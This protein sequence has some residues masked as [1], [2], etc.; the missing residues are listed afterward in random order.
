MILNQN[1]LNCFSVSTISTAF[2]SMN[3]L[4]YNDGEISRTQRGQWLQ[5][6]RPKSDDLFWVKRERKSLGLLGPL[7]S[8]KYLEMISPI[9]TLKL[10]VT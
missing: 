4:K 7:F 10:S 5:V 8:S 6:G 2:V 3:S 1:D 9:L